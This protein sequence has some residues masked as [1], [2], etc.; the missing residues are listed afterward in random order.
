MRTVDE[1]LSDDRVNEQ[2]QGTNFGSQTP[3]QVIA[4]SLLKCACG[5]YSGHT[6]TQICYNLG[7]TTKKWKL[8]ERGKEYLFCALEGYLK[9][10]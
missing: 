5:Y 6:A 3:R 9:T 8:S 7:L 1:I 10:L 2:F 4:S